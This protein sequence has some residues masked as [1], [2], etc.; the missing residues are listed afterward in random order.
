MKL[1][2]FDE[3]LGRARS[4]RSALQDYPGGTVP[5]RPTVSVVVPT[6]NEASGLQHLVS[7]IIAQDYDRIVEIFFVD[8]CSSDGTYETLLDLGGRDRKFRVLRNNKGQTAAGVNLALG[9][10]IGDV[11]IR[12][13]AHARFAPDV[14]R[15]S[16]GSL[17]RTGA[18][19][20]GAIAR[21]AQAETL[22]GRAI[23]SAH[24][25]PFGVGIA[26]FRKEGAEG[27]VDTVWNG[28][29]WRHVVDRVGP[30][31][32]DLHRAEDNDFNARVRRL[33]YGLYL[34]P[35]IRA[36]YEPRRTLGALW[37]Q[38]FANGVGVARA[39]L[40]SSGAV[41]MRH[42][43]PLG[44]VLSVVVPASLSLVFPPALLVTKIA[45]LGYAAVLLLSVLLAARNEPALHVALLPAVLATLHLS[46]GLGTSWGFVRG[47]FDRMNLGSG[48][49]I[50]TGDS[51]ERGDR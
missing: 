22:V 51:R 50:S 3:S 40:S 24:R 42:F 6:H 15:R 9:Q 21:P 45:L 4:Y 11:V 13:D 28:C 47:V 34:S 43:A 14:V 1:A 19:G 5:G 29:Y 17:L 48:T 49:R 20:V 30:L 23:V 33:G 36:L 46:Y 8:G 16:V 2:V 39:A 32:E 7:D 37:R 31:R 41:A 10:A 35:D 26:K 25:S 18:A 44:L 27:W 38:Y 12:L